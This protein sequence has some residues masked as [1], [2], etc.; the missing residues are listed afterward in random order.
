MYLIGINNSGTTIP[1]NKILAKFVDAINSVNV[2][3]E[4]D[5]NRNTEDYG[6]LLYLS[7]SASPAGGAFA[8]AIKG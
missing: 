8:P 3:S 7:A 4:H 2:E 5:I 6:T 1:A